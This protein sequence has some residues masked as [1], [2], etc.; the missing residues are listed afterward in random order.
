M[1]NYTTSKW[2]CFVEIKRNPDILEVPQLVQNMVGKVDHIK[3]K[4]KAARYKQ[5]RAILV[6]I[7][8]RWSVGLAINHFYD[9]LARKSIMW[10]DNKGKLS[11]RY[12]VP[13]DIIEWVGVGPL[14][15]KLPLPIE[16]E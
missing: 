1:K 6:N 11:P 9:F 8:N 14:A 13:Y 12:V 3:S 4:L 2:I 10:F 16:F 7:A 15:Y 5:K